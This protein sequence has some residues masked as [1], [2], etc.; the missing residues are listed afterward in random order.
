M[1]PFPIN[2]YLLSTV[3]ITVL[4]SENQASRLLLI[5]FLH[6]GSPNTWT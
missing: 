5:S 1:F 2:K 3:I 4:L 6:P